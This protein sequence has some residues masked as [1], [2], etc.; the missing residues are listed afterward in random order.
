MSCQAPGLSSLLAI[1]CPPNNLNINAVFKM[2]KPGL[3]RE[4][5][6]GSDPHLTDWFENQVHGTKAFSSFP[7]SQKAASLTPWF[8]EEKIHTQPRGVKDLAQ[9]GNCSGHSEYPNPVDSPLDTKWESDATWCCKCLEGLILLF[10]REGHRF[11][12]WMFLQDTSL[13][14][15]GFLL[16]R[17]TE[18]IV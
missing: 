14:T 10:A 11:Q 16:Y 8:M 9:S 13:T 7:W 12:S 1:I 3:Q 6:Q 4:Q 5:F 18:H 15:L 17:L 2:R